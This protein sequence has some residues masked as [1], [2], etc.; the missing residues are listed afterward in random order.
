MPSLQRGLPL[1]SVAIRW[2]TVQS[3]SLA[4]RLTI[5]PLPIQHVFQAVRV[6]CPVRAKDLSNDEWSV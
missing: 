5:V 6:V 3:K 2:G 1:F 4:V